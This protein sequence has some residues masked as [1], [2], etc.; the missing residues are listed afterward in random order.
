MSYWLLNRIRVLILAIV[1]E[2]TPTQLAVAGCI[3]FLMGLVPKT[4]VFTGGWV[5]VLLCLNVNIGFGFLMM[6]LSA[7]FGM[8]FDPV[9]HMIGTWL[10]VDMSVLRPLWVWMSMVPVVPYMR[11]NNTVVMGAMVCGFL[12]MPAVYYGVYFGVIRFR[13]KWLER[14]LKTRFV[15]WFG[16]SK[17]V[18]KGI[19]WLA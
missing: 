7:L 2:N 13:E 1:S 18:Q 4:V 5:L 16:A 6:G 9:F 17:W 12:L 14:L 3:G 8:L 11:F 19:Q 15:K 10:L